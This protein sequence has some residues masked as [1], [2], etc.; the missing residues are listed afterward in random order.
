M[1]PTRYICLFLLAAA[2]G[3]SQEPSDTGEL[4][5]GM[6][7]DARAMDT[8][9][10]RDV[11][12]NADAEPEDTAPP[13]EPCDEEGAMRVAS[14]GNC[15]MGQELCEDG[16]WTLTT[17]LGEGECAAGALETETTP[18][19]GMRTRLCTAAC[20]WMDWTVLEPDG[21]C[22]PGESDEVHDEASC[23]RSQLASRSCTDQCTWEITCID[24]CGDLQMEPWYEERICVP[25]G[26]F[27][28]GD[29]MFED[30]PETEVFLSTYAIDRYP[31]TYGR[32]R[33]CYDSGNCPSA[34]DVG[35]IENPDNADRPVNYSTYDGATEYCRFVGGEL[36]TAAQWE[37]AARGPAPRTNAWPFDGEWDCQ[38]YVDTVCQASGTPR[39]TALGLYPNARSYYGLDDLIWL[40]ERVRD[41]YAADYYAEPE[42]LRDPQGPTTGEV[43]EGRVF[44]GDRHRKRIGRRFEQEESRRPLGF[45]CAYTVRTQG[46]R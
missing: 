37:K 25:A 13:V 34:V 9:S 30:S 4:D 20:E 5:G 32:Y 27:V 26:P 42:S 39:E 36:P 43:R 41:W 38:I 7:A 15:G 31:V 17:C 2:C 8:G 10:D 14:C 23:G 21:E 3:E 44:G 46:G 24:P 18:M 33:A 6:T 40:N 12:S 29:S 45:R 35:D 22:M 16:V 1:R 19:C 11:A 28:R